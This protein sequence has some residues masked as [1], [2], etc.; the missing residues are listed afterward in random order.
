[1]EVGPWEQ[2]VIVNLET[3]GCLQVG[4]KHQLYER[5]LGSYTYHSKDGRTRL[6]LGRQTGA[7]EVWDIGPAAAPH[8]QHVRPANKRGD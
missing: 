7:V 4:R 2:V 8:V 5:V 6:V 1:M 3:G